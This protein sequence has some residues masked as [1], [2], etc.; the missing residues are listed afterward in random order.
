MTYDIIK[1]GSP[2]DTV[3]GVNPFIGRQLE[4][5]IQRHFILC[6]GA[7]PSSCKDPGCIFKRLA[8]GGGGLFYFFGEWGDFLQKN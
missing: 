6:R 3:G 7:Q 2:S 4:T 1:R 8:R 5:D